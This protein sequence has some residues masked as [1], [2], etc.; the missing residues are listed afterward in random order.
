[1]SITSTRRRST[2]NSAASLLQRFLAVRQFTERITDPLSAEDCLVQSMDDASPTRWHLAHTTW[3]FETFALNGQTGYEV[4]DR[5]FN[6]LFNSYYNSIGQQFPRSKRGLISRPGLA[7]IE[8][9]RRHVDDQIC[10][11]LESDDYAQQMADVLEVGLQHEQQHQELILTDIKH[12][13]AGNPT[14]PEYRAD[15]FDPTSSNVRRPDQ[16][17]AG[18]YQI[19]HSDNTFAYDNESPRHQVHLKGYRLSPSL[20]SCG[21]YLEFMEDDG[22]N[23]PEFWLS[24]GWNTVQQNGW[25][26]PLYWHQQD[27]QWLQY[28]LAG[29]APVDPDWPVCHVSLFEADAFARW[30]GKRLPTEF[31]WEVAARQTPEAVLAEAPFVD[32][33]IDRELAVHPTRQP[34]SLLGGLWQWT[35]SS[36]QAYPGYRPP[37]GAIGEYNGKFMCNQYVLR[38]GSVAT[39]ST[40][41]RPT[42]RNFFPTHTRWQFTGIRLATDAN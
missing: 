42:Y 2:T 18:N 29:L 38:G 35:S 14:F 33:L 25:C 13:L 27:G 12:A 28:T 11:R 19:G 6:Y 24:L 34:D 8:R 20:V 4:F 31:E 7:E 40:H 5:D 17:T 30:A 1:M 32:F 15:P 22:Y 41:I 10:Q 26:A 23:R 9:Y 37:D 3:F 16:I 21:E 36:Y 39:H